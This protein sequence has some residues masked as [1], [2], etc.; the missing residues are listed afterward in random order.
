MEGTEKLEGKTKIR[1]VKTRINQNVF[2]DI[3][4]INFNRKC[5]IT[6]FDN[7]DF[8]IAS[9]I[10]PWSKDKENRLNPGN[11]LLLNNLHDKAFEN[12]Y[13]AINKKYQILICSDFKK[14][15]DEFVQNYFRAYH[16]KEMN[17][18]ERFL[19]DI[20]FLEKHMEEKFLG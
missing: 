8:L 15:E 3:V 13:I 16:R 6:G 20:H 17:R 7:S 10:L 12:G 1:E 2:R 9:H 19:P 5:A 11:G 4:L 14:S 18:P